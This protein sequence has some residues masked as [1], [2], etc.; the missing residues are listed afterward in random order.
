MHTASNLRTYSLYGE[1]TGKIAPEF[2][3]IEP[4]SARSKLYDWSISPHT[5]PGIHQLL[6]L[7]RGAGLLAADGVEAGLSPSTLVAV[8]SH[9]VH[10]FRFDPGSEGWVFSFAIELLHDPRLN[11]AGRL[12]A[13]GRRGASLAHVDPED[14]NLSRLKWLFADLGEELGKHPTRE[15]RD[16]LIAQLALVLAV[17][18]E[19][20]DSSAKAPAPGRREALALEFRKLVDER[21]R[22]GWSVADYARQLGTTE[23]TLNRACRAVL[24]KSP[25]SVV[26]DRILLEAMRYLTYTSASV[27]QISG[28]LG[29]NDPAYFARFF[30]A[31]AGMTATRFREERAWLAETALPVRSDSGRARSRR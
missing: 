13:F 16:R 6:L 29:F 5:H 9:C 3:H 24:N 19:L 18:E 20:L 8:P 27:S 14:R 10:G 22:Q 28:N 2:L 12:E 1:V 23:P 26:H 30:K 7:T 25:G 11:L 17:S 21:Y 31:R 15:M 4:I